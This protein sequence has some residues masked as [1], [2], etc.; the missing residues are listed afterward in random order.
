M[1]EEPVKAS[2]LQVTTCKIYWLHV[3]IMCAS[4]H[5]QNK[6]KSLTT[7][8]DDLLRFT[9]INSISRSPWPCVASNI[10]AES[11]RHK[12]KWEPKFSISQLHMC[13]PTNQGNPRFSTRPPWSLAAIVCEFNQGLVPL[14]CWKRPRMCFAGSQVSLQMAR[15]MKNG[16]SL[17]FHKERTSCTGDL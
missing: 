4:D 13:C 8:Y 3:T 6:C 5:A 2:P 1:E 11:L 16:P 9:T 12:C 17:V 10:L 14:I 15:R 7:I